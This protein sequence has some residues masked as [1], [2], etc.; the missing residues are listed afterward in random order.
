MTW[1]A[2]A[3]W[4]QS[5]REEREGS[6]REALATIR[7]WRDDAEFSG[8]RLVASRRSP[9]YRTWFYEDRDGGRWCAEFLLVR[10]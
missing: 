1:K 3:I 8:F 5:A 6:Y 7:E 2:I 4:N 9:G 10:E